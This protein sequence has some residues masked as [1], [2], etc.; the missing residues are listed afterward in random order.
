M[1]NR[2][3]ITRP[4]YERLRDALKRLKTT[5]RRQVAREI[6]I[7]RGHGDLRENADYDAAKEKQGIL[8]ANIRDLED[9]LA[10]AE[11]IDP[12]SLKSERVVFGAT[13]TV[14]DLDDDEEQ[15]F[16]IVGEAEADARAG[17]I[18]VTS[19]MARALIGKEEGDVV[20]VR[21][22]GRTRELEVAEIRFE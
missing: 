17:R 19:P 22:P 6:E 2:M 7:A 1:S 8:E 9:K 14:L 16:Q 21:A 10:R 18:S 5:E 4:G 13:V 11:V 3:P 12:A 15:S 20:T